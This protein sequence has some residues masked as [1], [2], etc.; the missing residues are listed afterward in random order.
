M[1]FWSSLI[2][3]GFGGVGLNFQFASRFVPSEIVLPLSYTPLKC[4]N[5]ALSK[6]SYLI[7]SFTSFPTA[8]KKDAMFSAAPPPG[9]DDN[10]I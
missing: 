9:L 1:A 4:H 8:E 2:T 5:M 3:L 6:C 10:D 7:D